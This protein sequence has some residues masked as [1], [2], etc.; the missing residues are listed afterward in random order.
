MLK[1]RGLEWHDKKFQ[2]FER[3]L[4]K[5]CDIEEIP[6]LNRQIFSSTDRAIEGG[7]GGGVGHSRIMHYAFTHCIWPVLRYVYT[8]RLVENKTFSSLFLTLC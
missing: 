5:I 2:C 1:Q 8:L 7:G 3:F 6:L 4:L